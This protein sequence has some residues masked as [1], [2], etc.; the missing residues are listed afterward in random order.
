MRMG[1][2]T[3]DYFR[4]AESMRGVLASIESE[5]WDL[6]TPCGVWTVR[7]VANHVAS[8]PHFLASVATGVPLKTSF[9]R[10]SA[11]P[12][13]EAMAEALPRWTP[14][15]MIGEQGEDAVAVMDEGLEELRS[16][17]DEPGLMDKVVHAGIG[18]YPMGLV[19]AV[20]V[21]EWVIHGWDLC[22]ALG[23]YYPVDVDLVTGTADFLEKSVPPEGGPFIGPRLVDL[24][25]D[26]DPATRL[27]IVAGRKP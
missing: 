15:D 21:G 27:A 11:T 5:Q 3:D 24:P 20:N 1:N 4:A 2:A 25:P 17:L 10:V 14:R 18:D 13:A 23:V 26:A 9:E 12:F 7:E 6:P 16:R 22:H 19:M 8:N